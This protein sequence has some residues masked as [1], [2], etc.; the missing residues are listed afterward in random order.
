MTAA[1]Q[2]EVLPAL[3]SFGCIHQDKEGGHVAQPAHGGREG[4]GNSEEWHAA[5]AREPRLPPQQ[6]PTRE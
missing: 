1:P 6:L 3:V 5:V 4:C 2:P